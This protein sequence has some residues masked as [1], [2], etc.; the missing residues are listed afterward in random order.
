MTPTDSTETLGATA[1]GVV[2]NS[3][4]APEKSQQN[5]PRVKIAGLGKRA[6]KALIVEHKGL[7]KAA[8]RRYEAAIGRRV[9]P[10]LMSKVFIGA[11]VSGPVTRAIEAELAERMARQQEEL[12]V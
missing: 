7:L 12:A 5:L 9:C 10:S 11:S 1:T 6:R 4:T 2:R 8:Q 3:V